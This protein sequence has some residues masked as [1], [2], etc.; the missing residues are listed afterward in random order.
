MIRLEKRAAPSTKAAI[1]SPLIAIALTVAC[2][3]LMIQAAGKSPGDA[4]DAYFLFPFNDL[5]AYFAAGEEARASLLYQPAEVV[6]KAIPLA[7]I[8]VGLAVAFRAGIFNIGAA[9]QYILGAI[10]AGAVALYAP[11]T[12]PQIILL[13]ACLIAGTLGGLLWALIPAF[14]RVRAGASEI[15]TSLMLTYVAGYLLDWVV[16]GPWRDPLG[17]GFPQSREF[18]EATAMPLLLEGTRLH[19]GLFV[20]LAVVAAVWFA[21]ARTIT[22]FRVNITG[23]A[24]RAAHF[25]GF[26]QG[27]T[28]YVVFLL[29][30]ALAGL[31]GALET[32]AIIGQLQPE[33]SAEYGFAAIIVAFLGRLHPVG[34][35][36]AALVLALTYIGGENAQITLGLP[37][38]ATL[39]FQG[40][41]LLF[42]LACDA[43]IH[44]RLRW[45]TTA[46]V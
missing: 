33:I 9:G 30:G 12:T 37:R 28:I 34:V 1:L 25:A 35:L 27:R 36:L 42:L 31:A 10:F 22:G 16:R 39:V 32:T 2:G 29:S 19:W 26:Q 23:L 15:L 13:P 20:M 46:R 6:L 24:P 11:D 5:K 17:F 41:L 3:L 38:N 18:P 40:M 21:M 4:V 8:G 7:L 14:L 44:Y 43:M 45:R